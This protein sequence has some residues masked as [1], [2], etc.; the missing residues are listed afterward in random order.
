M[1]TTVYVMVKVTIDP[2]AD[3]YKVIKELNYEFNGDGV[4][5]SEIIDVAPMDVE[6]HP[7]I[8]A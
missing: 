5:D 4:I 8:A 1:S 3:P 6:E 7:Y 2:A